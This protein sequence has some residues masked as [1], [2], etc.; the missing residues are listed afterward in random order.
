MLPGRKKISRNV[1]IWPFTLFSNFQKES[2]DSVQKY[3][4]CHSSVHNANLVLIVL[5]ILYVRK[6]RGT[7]MFML[8]CLHCKVKHLICLYFPPFSWFSCT[9]WVLPGF[10]IPTFGETVSKLRMNICIVKHKCLWIVYNIL[11]KAY[12]VLPLSQS[13]GFTAAFDY[14][15]RSSIWWMLGMQ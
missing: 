1:T 8:M 11:V 4:E 14:S 13:F 5:L 15:L 2:D 9:V 3:S 10:G 12:S 6:L 7:V